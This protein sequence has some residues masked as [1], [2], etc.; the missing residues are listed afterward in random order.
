MNETNTVNMRRLAKS[1]VLN[2]Y[3]LINPGSEEMGASQVWLGI[4]GDNV[5]TIAAATDAS[6]LGFKIG[7]YAAVSSSRPNVLRVAVL[8]GDTPKVYHVFQTSGVLAASE[9]EKSGFEL[10]CWREFLALRETEK[11]PSDMGPGQDN[12]SRS[13]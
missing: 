5:P 13:G 12:F 6:Y 10:V 4:S 7:P 8:C 9:I 1:D 2:M 3:D 11:S